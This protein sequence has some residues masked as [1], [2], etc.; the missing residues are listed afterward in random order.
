MDL[1]AEINKQVG[2]AETNTEALW[3][4]IQNLKISYGR[5][6][7]KEKRVYSGDTLETYQYE[8]PVGFGSV[9]GLYRKPRVKDNPFRVR[10]DFSISRARLHIRRLIACNE[11]QY[12]CMS[13]FITY[14]IAENVTDLKK[15]N[16][17]WTDYCR[18]LNLYLSFRALYV[19]VVE[20]QKRGA[21]H[22]H[23]VYF[24]LPY[25]ENIKTIFANIWG[26]GFITIKAIKH[27]ESV[28][29]Y[30]SKYLQKGVVDKR[31]FCEKV[32]FSSRGLKKPLV[33]RYPLLDVDNE[34][35]PYIMELKQVFESKSLWTG[36][37]IYKRYLRK[38][39]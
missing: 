15:A 23:C 18:R 14:T 7:S 24:N 8:F 4:A 9:A 37:T 17:K 34:V 38:K 11:K 22:Y 19:C 36:R 6:Y 29:G 20:F 32:Y 3:R 28:G 2:L 30:V 13:V 33:L 12:G 21:V 10:R 27:I 16:R 1:L 5:D 31:L 26:N 25:I 39:I 35:D